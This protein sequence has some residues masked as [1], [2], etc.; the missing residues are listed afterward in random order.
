M[1]PTGAGLDLSF[2]IGNFAPS[3]FP[4]LSPEF[5]RGFYP[6]ETTWTEMPCQFCVFSHKRDKEQ[7][8]P[9]RSI[10]D[11]PHAYQSAKIQC[12]PVRKP[13]FFRLDLSGDVMYFIL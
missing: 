5:L 6:N 9:P 11:F 13:P 7:F 1:T 10:A 8:L 12:L 3:L 2:R 4:D